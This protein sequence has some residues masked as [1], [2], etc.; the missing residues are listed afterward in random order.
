MIPREE[1]YSLGLKSNPHWK[2]QKTHGSVDGEEVAEVPRQWDLLKTYSLGTNESVGLWT[3]L[4][5]RAGG[6]LPGRS[7]VQEKAMTL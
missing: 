1:P 7:P 6:S 3:C 5:L 2:G 4:E